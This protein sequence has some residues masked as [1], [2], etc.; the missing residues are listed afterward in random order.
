MDEGWL[1]GRYANGT[2]YE[3]RS[4]FPSGMAALGAYVHGLDPRMRYG[5][6]DCRGTEQCGTSSYSAPGG[7]GHEAQDVDW[8]SSAG[9]DWIKVDR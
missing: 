7:F 5:L 1:Q 2:L 3:D 9:A 8:M 6:Y 4:K